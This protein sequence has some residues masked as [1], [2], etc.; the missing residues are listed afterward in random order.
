MKYFESSGLWSLADDSSNTVGGTLILDNE[1]LNLKLL[2]TF[3]ADWAAGVERYPTIH[4]VI[5]DNPY[6]TY[7]T[8]IDCFRKHSVI[9]MAGVTSE[10][11]GCGRATIGATHLSDEMFNFET[12][13]VM[14]SYLKDWVGITGFKFDGSG[15]REY[16]VNYTKPELPSFSFGEKKLTLDPFV[17]TTRG[18]HHAA[19]DEEI[20]ILVEPVGERLPTELGEEGIQVLQNL[21]TFATDTPNAIEEITYY[22]AADDRGVHP[23]YHLVFDPIL[24][25]KEDKKPLHASDMLF[26]FRDAQDQGLNIF[27]NWLGFTERNR[28]FCT[29]FS[30]ICMQ[31]LGI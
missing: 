16:S 15:G 8:L 2:G 26:T 4:G 28:S 7:V 13:E 25:L 30:Q 23:D 24:R 1:G 11:I 22:G 12:L 18:M 3:S 20:L 31:S 14:F 10:T 21:L 6:G 19:L 17:K 5:G 9:N 27:Q 29:I